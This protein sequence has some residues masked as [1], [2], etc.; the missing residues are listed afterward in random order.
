VPR[1]TALDTGPLYALFDRRDRLHSDSRAFI[2]AYK[3]TLYTTTAV[4][5]EATFLLDFS[6]RAQVNL[7]RWVVN[8]G[9]RIVPLEQEDLVRT[10]EIIQK[11]A[12]LP[13]DFADASLV[14]I[15][16]RL[17]IMEIATVDR[18]FDIYRTK[19]RQRLKNVFPR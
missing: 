18:D 4:L 8:G 1:R 3:G 12:D 19:K 9:V 13:A 5:T 14:T 10:A 17:E 11:Y 6:V 16:E 2:K 15:C 7:L